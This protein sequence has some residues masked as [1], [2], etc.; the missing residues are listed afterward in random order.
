[1]LVNFKILLLLFPLLCFS[2]NLTK[3]KVLDEDL[4]P[5]SRAL[6]VISSNEKQVAFGTTNELGIFEKDLVNGSY[7]IK[8][9]KLG[10]VA[11]TK[12]VAVENSNE[13]T[14]VL[15]NE[16][17]KL[18]TVIIKS[19]PKIMKI[20]GDTISY[21][22][23]AIADGTE[24]KVEDLIKKL[25]GLNVDDAGKVSYKGQDIDKVLID[26]NEFFNN[27]HQ[28]ATQNIDANMVEGIDLLL[29]HTGFSQASGAEKSV[30][31]NLKMK[32][33][34]KNKW[35]G[36]VDFGLGTKDAFKI[37][38]NLFKFFK[39]GNIAIIMDYNSIAKT[40]I[41]FEDYNEMQTVSAVSFEEQN[42]N[43]IEM[44]SFLNPNSYFTEKKNSF[45]G[46]H[47]TTKFSEKS[48]ITI[49]NIFNNANIVESQ[50]KN[51]TNIGE[52]NA[53]QAYSDIKTADYSLNNTYLKWEYNKS[54]KTYFSYFA[55]FTPNFDDENNTIN[56][57][58]QSLNSEKNQANISFSQQ[59]HALTKLTDKINYKFYFKHRY[60][61]KDQALNLSALNPLFD[62]TLTQINQDLNT[63]NNLVNIINEFSTLKKNN[64][65]SLKVNFLSTTA[66]YESSISQNQNFSNNLDF[67][68]QM[69]LAYPSWL[70]NWS[71][72]FQ[73][74]FGAKMSYS[75]ID[76]TTNTTTF[77]RFEPVVSLVYNL[78]LLDKVSF[79]YSL[80]HDLPQIDQLQNNQT[81]VDFQTVYGGS[82]VSFNKVIP[83]SDFSADYLKINTRTQSVF[84]TRISYGITQ[85]AIATNSSYFTNYAAN[86]F[87][88]TDNSK[89]INGILYYDLKFNTLPFS[90][91]NTGAYFRSEGFSQ[92]DGFKN[93]LKTTVISGKSQLIST[94][95]NSNIQF[96]LGLNI[97][98]TQFSQSINS[99]AN[100]TINTRAN[101]N[102]RGKFKTFIKW[103]VEIIRDHQN[104][105]FSSNKIDFLNANVQYNISPKLKINA[106]G[107]NLL[108]L[109]TSD[110]IKTSVNEAYFTET[111]TRIL[112]GYILVGLAY[113]Y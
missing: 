51:Q 36:E 46:I 112:P 3:I 37:H 86:N 9:S 87:V 93:K 33:G 50:F 58:E 47:Y 20:K 113:S 7:T 78:G 19:R 104:S 79:N 25:P 88:T 32:D 35:I 64:L 41:S 76:F 62:T 31:L 40:P 102:L 95:K 75:K 85:N 55:G 84:F 54:K 90:I 106:N 73:T 71:S 1:M 101:L 80:S 5:I 39:K 69:V 60:Q 70:R 77:L 72:K 52:T 42:A 17:N 27:K 12:D 16:V 8:A 45:V 28:M 100:K 67:N 49:T 26:G 56:S 11:F 34:F 111:V 6:L 82:L 74:T 24:N 91:K 63:Q 99:F 110:I 21:N 107:F 65:F 105:E 61:S 38:N 109:D 44:P 10:Y 48:K 15:E 22:I 98:Q 103:N 59:F 94:I 68:R 81:I 97:R 18:E 108:N 53:T 57:A 13:V 96:D 4:K 23:K 14:F 43:Q 92:F 30:A 83:R 89:Q 2:Q 66:K 29:N